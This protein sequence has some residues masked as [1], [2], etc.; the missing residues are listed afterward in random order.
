VDGERPRDA[1]GEDGEVTV[2]RSEGLSIIVEIV[3]EGR[4]KDVML[5]RR[6]LL[7]RPLHVSRG[8]TIC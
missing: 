3:D 5:V 7:L 8:T 2:L 6:E 1:R 4:D